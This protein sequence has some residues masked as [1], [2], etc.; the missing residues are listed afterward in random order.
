MSDKIP[1]HHSALPH[2]RAQRIIL[3]DADKQREM[4]PE[5][6]EGLQDCLPLACLSFDHQWRFTGLNRQAEQLLGRTTRELLGKSLWE[7]YPG[8][9]GSPYEIRYRASLAQNLPLAFEA[10]DPCLLHWCSVHTIPTQDGLAISFADI[11]RSKQT[12]LNKR[13]CIEEERD[14]LFMREQVARAEAEAARQRLYDLFMQAPVPICVVR[15]P[16]HIFELANPLRLQMAGNRKLVGKPI[17]EAQPELAGQGWFELLDRAYSTGEP[18]R[19]TEGKA[20]L[21]R[22]N[23][24]KLEEAYFNYIFQPTRNAQ[25]QIDGILSLGV[26][27]TEQVRTRQALQAARAEAEAARQHIYNLFMQA[28]AFIAVVRGPLHVFELTNLTYMHLIGHREVIGKPVREA[29]PEV[30]GQGFFELLDQVYTTGQLYI[31]TEAKIMLD[32][33]DDGQLEE[34][35][36]NFIYQPTYNA[37]GEV[38]GVLALG[39]DVTEQVRARQAVQESQQRLELAQQAGQIG[40]FEWDIQQH[41]LWTTEMEALYGLSAGEFEGSYQDWVRRVSPLDLPHFEER[42]LA[43]LAD[44]GPWHDEFRVVWPDGSIHW[45]SGN[46]V[47]WMDARCQPVRMIGVNVDITERKTLDE[48]KDTFIGVVSHELKTPVTSLKTY[49]ELLQWRFEHAGDA[50]SAQV[51]SRMD[52]QIDRLTALIQDLL[53]VT[54]L[55]VGQLRITLE[56]IDLSAIVRESVETMQQTTST[57]TILIEE[58][59]TPLPKVHADPK[60]I[61]QVITNL[62][63]NAIKYSP[64]DSHVIVK[65]TPALHEIT[66]SVQ[67]YG[68]GIARETQNRLFQRFFRADGALEESQPGLGLGLYIASEIIAHHGGRINVKSEVGQGS[69]FFFT[70]PVQPA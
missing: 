45:L 20:M 40:T 54:Q 48:Q 3:Q 39:V 22:H 6:A 47:I 25:G 58:P 5:A 17:R 19:V 7:E 46:A 35:Y 8:Y 42:L 33:R 10:F 11:T 59:D 70:L 28:P 63:S 66:V 64:A 26:E 55:E 13:R 24:G 62:L 67:D 65:L 49:T 14:Q 57:H 51:L 1:E 52:K 12:E 36:C 41:M 18:V 34:V 60:R 43:A 37:Q 50:S 23:D 27:V 29:L 44:G 69:T 31:G 32:S 68:S 9:L 56:L 4:P 15:G 30:E 16:E 53:D 21:D 2:R 61:A 38:D